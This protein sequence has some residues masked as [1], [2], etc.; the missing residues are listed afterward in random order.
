MGLFT[1]PRQQRAATLVNSELLP[2]RAARYNRNRIVTPETA[3]RQSAVWGALRLRADI[4]STAPVDVFR[5]V[6]GVQVEVPKQP[7][8]SDPSTTG[9]GFD[10][11]M[12][13]T[14][15]D[16]DRCGNAV[17]II[18]EVDG[19]GKPAKI[20][21]VDHR[22]VVVGV[23]DDV[24]YYRIRG[25]EYPKHEI[26]HERQ[27]TVPGL[28][29][30]LSPVAH[31]AW[32]LGLWDSAMQ[33]GMEW[34]ANNGRIPSGVLK[35]LQKV[36]TKSEAQQVKEQYKA[37]VEAGDI[38]VTGKDWEFDLKNAAA[39]DAKFMEMNKV[40]DVDAVR[41]FGVPADLIEVDSN[42]QH[43]TYANVSQRN[44]QFLIVNMGPAFTRR[45][46]ALSRITANPRFV[47]LNSDAVV[48]R[49]DPETR[50]KQLIAEVEGRITAPSEARAFLNRAPFTPE[51]IAEFDQLFPRGTTPQKANTNGEP[52]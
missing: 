13:S 26:W 46:N 37:S 23:K 20:D 42:R 39:A 10:E 3:L 15:M 28:V 41:F 51:Q 22:D 50:S 43:V 31:M 32:S 24:I 6:A 34:F 4:M 47:K 11:W 2:G 36:L 1:G 52:K 30:G 9:I 19:L 29:V 25:K 40:T 33:F 18:R 44:L 49:M 27:F 38:F 21:L 45:E 16:L 17:G 5:K 35:N 48:L 12:Y 7:F 8:F 14:Q